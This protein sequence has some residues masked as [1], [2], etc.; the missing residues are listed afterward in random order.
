[1]S[2]TARD[3]TMVQDL[4]NLKAKVDCII[5]GAFSN[6]ERLHCVVR[7]SFES[8]VNKRQNKPAELIGTVKSVS[9]N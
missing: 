1:M 9:L 8:V 7:E 5:V 4:L 6:N 2:D 3:K